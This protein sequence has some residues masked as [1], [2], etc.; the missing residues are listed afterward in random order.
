MLLSAGCLKPSGPTGPVATAKAIE[1]ADELLWGPAAFGAIGDIRM[2]NGRLLAVITAVDRAVG[3]AVSGGNI[4]DVARL[5]GGEDQLNQ[6]TLYL[7]DEFP[8]QAR[9]ESLEIRSAGGRRKPAVVRAEGVDT[10][11]AKIEVQTDYVLEPDRQWLTLITRFTNTGT[12]TIRGYR[13]GDAIQW[14]RAEHMAPKEGF[15][16]PGRRVEV[17]WVAGV[18]GGTSYAYV[19]DGA[20]DVDVLNGSMWSD[21]IADPIDLPPGKPVAYVRHLVVGDGDTASLSGAIATIRKQA[22]GRITGSI[23]HDG[24]PVSGAIVHVMDAE[25]KLVGLAKVDHDGWYEIQVP[26]G[27]YSLEARAPGREPSAPTDPKPRF[28]V[29]ADQTVSRGFRLGPHASLGWRISGDGR[30]AQPVKVTVVGLDGTADPRLGPAFD[31]SGAWNLVLSPRGFGTAPVGM[32]KFRVLVSRGP[33][34]ELIEQVVQVAEGGHAEV[35][36]KLVRSVDT[37]GF[38]AAD[39]HQHAAPSFDSG[40]SPADRAL[41]NATEG[42]EV[43]VSTDHNVVIDYRPVIAANGLGRSVYSIVGT[44][45]TTHSVGHF[46]AFPLDIVRSDPRGGMRDPEGWT[47]EKI[48]SFVRSLGHDPKLPPFIQ[49][50]HPRA[51]PIGYFDLMDLDPATGL[52]K[53]PRFV[54][55]F[56]GMEVISF[57]WANETKQ[58]V[59]DWFALLNRGLRITATGNSDS[60]TIF[61]REV[62]WART[63]VCVDDDTPYRLDVGAFIRA[64]RSGCATVSAGPFLTIRSGAVQMGGTLTAER[65]TFEIQVRL[66]AAS[67]IPTDQLELYVNGVLERTI[68][69]QGTAPVRFDDAIR[70]TCKSDCY[71]VAIARSER[72]LPPVVTSWRRRKPRPIALTNPIYVDADGD[73]RY[74]RGAP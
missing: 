48:F 41:S 16:L 55:N 57:G 69:L 42:V 31:A 27:D 36:G 65:A 6:I 5:P 20:V 32:G 23:T 66:Q 25:G 4:I 62:G 8:R 71:V 22:F 10:K 33:E 40:V 52:A 58:S 56:D 67:W 74:S 29:A 13:P 70:L 15:G 72:R 73:G 61:G 26:P 1:A 59:A 9:Y 11:N 44:E 64:L 47:P 53:D 34:Y 51:G 2:S 19:P 37:E 17:G 14:G 50:N 24:A 7:D 21:P 46:N 12:A 3:F 30:F 45:A 68:A 54:T 63:Y 49:V 39:L 28:A 18:G 38:V 35:S 60:H 43:L